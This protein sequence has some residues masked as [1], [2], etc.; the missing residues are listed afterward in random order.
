M[1]GPYR[2]HRYRAL[3]YGL[4]ILKSPIADSFEAAADYYDPSNSPPDSAKGQS[5]E[6][7]RSIEIGAGSMTLD[8]EHQRALALLA[9]NPK[10]RTEVSHGCTRQVGQQ[11]GTRRFCE[12]AVTRE[13]G[14]SRRHGAKAE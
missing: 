2:G 13:V 10:G 6:S 3:A 9:R 1:K 12:K 8:G 4:K 14:K 5:L 11:G 7:E